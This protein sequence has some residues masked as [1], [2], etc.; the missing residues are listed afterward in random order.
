MTPALTSS[1]TT[2]TGIVKQGFRVGARRAQR[3]PLTEV[4]Q[5]RWNRWLQAA[6]LIT[7]LVSVTTGAIVIVITSTW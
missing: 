3:S 2:P 6:A 4:R 1:A 7:G 5:A